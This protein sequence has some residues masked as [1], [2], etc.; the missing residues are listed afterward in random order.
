MVPTRLTLGILV[1]GIILTI[2]SFF[3]NSEIAMISVVALLLILEWRLFLYDKRITDILSGTWCHRN[4]SATLVRQ[5]TPILVSLRIKISLPIDFSG[6]IIDQIP[7]GMVLND[8]IPETGISA[9]SPREFLIQYSVTPMLYGSH[10]FPGLVIT[11]Q[12]RFFSDTLHLQTKKFSGPEVRVYPAGDYEPVLGPLEYGEQEIEQFRALSGFGVR[13]F[14]DFVDGDHMKSIDWK[15]TAKFDKFIVREYTGRVGSES[16]LMVDLPDADSGDPGENF[17]KMIQALSGEVE[18]ALQQY[19]RIALVFISGPNVVR[20]D[21]FEKD[22]NEAM[23]IFQNTANPVKRLHTY[24]RYK[25]AREMRALIREI[26]REEAVTKDQSDGK[27]YLTTL[28]K[29]STSL[30]DKH[31]SLVFEGEISRILRMMPYKEVVIFSVCSGD[32][33]HIRFMIDEIHKLHGYAYLNI[34][35]V[36]AQQASLQ[37]YLAWGT[38]S[39]QVF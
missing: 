31:E 22:L 8:A 39:V 35:G 3:L 29:I 13:G 5:G 15:L 17:Q 21:Q 23:R 12:D 2:Y 14:R 20:S 36:A 11:V 9:A 16:L 18:R 38:D 10:I 33:S 6:R 26:S 19:H 27:H 1:I 34:P 7:V 24:Y 25:T 32:L 28:A 37:Q 4:L 30:S